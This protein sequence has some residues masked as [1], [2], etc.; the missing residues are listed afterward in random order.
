MSPNTKVCSVRPKCMG[1]S[2]SGQ[3]QHWRRAS[4][5]SLLNRCIHRHLLADE[6]CPVLLQVGVCQIALKPWLSANTAGEGK[7]R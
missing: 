4:S 3:P 7:H 6:F 2:G 5:K 1:A